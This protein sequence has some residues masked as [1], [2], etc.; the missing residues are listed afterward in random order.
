MRKLLS[1]WSSF[2]SLLAGRR[3]RRFRDRFLSVCLICVCIWFWI[4]KE[5]S[6]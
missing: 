4:V 2:W 6:L 1:F 3:R 5:V